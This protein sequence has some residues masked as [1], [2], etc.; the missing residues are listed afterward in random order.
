MSTKLQITGEDVENKSKSAPA[1]DGPKEEDELSRTSW[2]FHIESL[3]LFGQVAFL[4][5]LGICAVITERSGLESIPPP[6]ATEVFRIFG[7]NHV[8][9]YIDHNP[10]KTFAG[11]VIPLYTIPMILYVFL[12]HSRLKARFSTRGDVPYW[13]VVFSKVT[14]PYNITSFALL[15]MW[16]VNS[17]D[18]DYGFVA[19]YVPYLMYQVAL[20]LLLFMNVQYLISTK[21]LPGISKSRPWLA[22]TYQ[23]FSLGLTFV[24]ICGVITLLA[25][26]PILDSKN[27]MTEQWIFRVISYFYGFNI[28]IAP[29]VL[30]AIERR[31]GDENVITYTYK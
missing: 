12:Y 24:S 5:T 20:S 3:R 22:W 19:H 15:H 7:F 28:V 4:F 9:N 6:E 11:L 13:L 10:S 16:F 17:P 1:S 21:N 23:F 29:I 18:G 30:S 27:N 8:C 31:N 25:G 26:Y 14:L 2:T